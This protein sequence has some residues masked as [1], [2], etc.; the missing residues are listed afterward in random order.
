MPLAQTL[1][2]VYESTLASTDGLKQEEKN[3]CSGFALISPDHS[4]KKLIS[5]TI[6]FE[7]YQVPIVRITR[8][9]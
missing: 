6:G 9:K 4:A 8:R 1:N 3:V 7:K 2:L 5:K